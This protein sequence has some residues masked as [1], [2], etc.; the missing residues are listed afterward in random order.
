MASGLLVFMTVVSVYV[1]LYAKLG[2]NCIMFPVLEELINSGWK[3]YRF[4]HLEQKFV[5]YFII[6]VVEFI[7]LM[8]MLG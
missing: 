7:L 4:R 8:V 3:I 5:T 6:G 1:C 2:V